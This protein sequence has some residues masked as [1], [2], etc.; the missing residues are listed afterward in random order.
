MGE[1][2][3]L[4][5]TGCFLDLHKGYWD[6]V[7][8]AAALTRGYAAIRAAGATL[9]QWNSRQKHYWM[10]LQDRSCLLVWRCR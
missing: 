5:L 1:L 8:A 10:P 2:S 4:K 9:H 3:E 6:Q 7:Q